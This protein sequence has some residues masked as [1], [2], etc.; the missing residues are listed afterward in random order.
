MAASAHAVARERANLADTV[1]GIERRLEALAGRSASRP[2][3]EPVP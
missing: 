2:R 1:D 3:L